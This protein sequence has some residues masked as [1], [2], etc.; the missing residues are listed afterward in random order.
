MNFGTISFSDLDKLPEESIKVPVLLFYQVCASLEEHPFVEL[1][2]RNLGCG[3][4]FFIYQLNIG[5]AFP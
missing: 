1:V 3:C 5:G 4:V 2:D